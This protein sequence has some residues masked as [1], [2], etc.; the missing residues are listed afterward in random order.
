MR[1]DQ[2]RRLALWVNGTYLLAADHSGLSDGSVGDDDMERVMDAKQA[3]A[4]DMIGRSGIPAG[5]DEAEA[6]RMVTAG[7]RVPR[8]T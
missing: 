7:E 3:I 8:G 6:I 1:K 5:V 2:A 4:L